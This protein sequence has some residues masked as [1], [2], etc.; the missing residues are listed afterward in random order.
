MT[1]KRG[2]MIDRSRNTARVLI[3]VSSEKD[4]P[5]RLPSIEEKLRL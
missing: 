5:V 1:P 3:T 2:H 4:V